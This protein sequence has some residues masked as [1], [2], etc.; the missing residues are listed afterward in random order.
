M[1]FLRLPNFPVFNVADMS[2]TVAAVMIVGLSLFNVPYD[3][4]EPADAAA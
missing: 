3:R 4:H 2:L 1:D